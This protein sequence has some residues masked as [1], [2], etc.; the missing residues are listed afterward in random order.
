VTVKKRL[1]FRVS[2]ALA[3]L[4]PN[5][6]GI[7]KPYHQID[8]GF[9]LPGNAK[10][11]LGA[12]LLSAPRGL[13]HRYDYKAICQREKIGVV[14]RTLE[15]FERETSLWG[16]VKA[17]TLSQYEKL[18]VEVVDIH[19]RDFIAHFKHVEPDF[20]KHFFNTMQHLESCQA[21]GKNIYFH[22]KAGK[23]R[24]FKALTTYLVFLKVKDKLLD[25]S[26]DDTELKAIIQKTCETIH[27]QRPQIIYR[28]PKQKADH[29]A[30]VFECLKG[31]RDF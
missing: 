27:A 29:E 15:P 1:F 9:T 11:F 28:N 19:I 17:A 18:G 3:T 7:T 8:P 22:C 26:L 14:V 21:S 16:G 4:A 2:H 24:S 25:K 20:L 10:V 12:M 13:Y 6:F 31:F 23:N 30:F 5:F